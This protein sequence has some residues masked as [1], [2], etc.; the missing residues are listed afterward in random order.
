MLYI[1]G[2]K[3]I[4]RIKILLLNTEHTANFYDPLRYIIFC[5]LCPVISYFVFEIWVNFYISGRNLYTKSR[6]FFSFKLSRLFYNI[7]R[8][9]NLYFYTFVIQLI[10]I[11]CERRI[12][13][14]YARIYNNLNER[15][16]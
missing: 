9:I 3:K 6:L 14:K 10:N 5:N 13:I 15:K 4:F 1:R 11:S 12:V 7:R 8:R 16:A 2:L